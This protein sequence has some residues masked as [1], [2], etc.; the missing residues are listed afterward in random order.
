MNLP[1][2]AKLKAYLKDGTSDALSAVKDFSNIVCSLA[3]LESVDLLSG[4]VTP[5]MVQTVCRGTVI[6]FPLKEIQL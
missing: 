4:E 2:G 5:D 1:A 3:K 6:L